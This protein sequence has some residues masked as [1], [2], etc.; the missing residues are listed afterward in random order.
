MRQY[1]KLHSSRR[2][3][4][5]LAAAHGA[6]LAALLFVLPL[7][8]GL[9]LAA[10]LVV[11]LIYYLLRDAWRRLP[12]SCIGLVLEDEGVVLHRRDGVQVSCVIGPGSL[13]T[14][15]L[16]VLHALPQGARLARSVVILPDSLDAE[17]FRKLRVWLKWGNHSPNK[18]PLRH[19]EHEGHEKKREDSL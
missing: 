18:D 12:G 6:A 10:A 16:T 7:R 1:I 19:E 8:A 2:L 15:A 17:S 5:L 13:V 14:P 4:A 3:T 9:A 11:S